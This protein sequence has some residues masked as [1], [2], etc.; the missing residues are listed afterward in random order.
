MARQKLLEDVKDEVIKTYLAGGAMDAIADQFG[1]A[2]GTVSNALSRWGVR[3]ADAHHGEHYS[4]NAE[5]LDDL[6]NPDTREW[7]EYLADNGRIGTGVLIL[8]RPLD[9]LD[10]II[11]LQTALGTNKPPEILDG[12]LRLRIYSDKIINQ[13]RDYKENRDKVSA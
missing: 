10:E 12:R 5:A 13:V 6:N 9:K 11:S 1:V 4:I 3:R 7:L 8:V 2:I